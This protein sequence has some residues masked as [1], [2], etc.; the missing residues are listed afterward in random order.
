MIIIIINNLREKLEPLQQNNISISVDTVKQFL[1]EE[2]TKLE[3][4]M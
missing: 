1:N 4:A 3:G 2:S